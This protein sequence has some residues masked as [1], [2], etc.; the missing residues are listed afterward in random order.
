MILQV[1]VACPE[2]L[3]PYQIAR[4]LGTHYRLPSGRR[5]HATIGSGQHLDGIPMNT[6]VLSAE[7]YS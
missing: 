4:I 1:T 2:G 7:D 3:D 5:C 6:I